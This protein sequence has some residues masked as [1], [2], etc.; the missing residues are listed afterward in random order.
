MS[1]TGALKE[2]KTCWIKHQYQTIAPASVPTS[3]D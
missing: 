3:K 1:P 2:D